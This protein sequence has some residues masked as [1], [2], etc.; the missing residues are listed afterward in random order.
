MGRCADNRC[1]RRQVSCVLTPSEMVPPSKAPQRPG[2]RTMQTGL[3]A[4]WRDMFRR[5]RTSHRGEGHRMYRATEAQQTWRFG[6]VIKLDV[7]GEQRTQGALEVGTGVKG[8]GEG[9]GFCLQAERHHQGCMI[10][11]TGD[12]TVC[13]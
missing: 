12:Q 2:Y 13:L 9:P 1:A 4:M 6:G 11:C 7:A 5:D 3:M 10:G 8:L